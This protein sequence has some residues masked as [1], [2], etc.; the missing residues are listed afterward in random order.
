MFNQGDGQSLG[1][2]S[3]IHEAFFEGEDF[4]FALQ[5][6]PKIILCGL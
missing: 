5:I 2:L 3:N 6:I 4:D 1:V